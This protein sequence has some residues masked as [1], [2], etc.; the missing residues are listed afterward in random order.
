MS[1]AP[2][3]WIL[4]RKRGVYKLQLVSEAKR[5]CPQL[6]IILGED[7]SRFRDVSKTLAQFLRSFTWSEKCER[8]GFDEAWLDCTDMIDYSFSHLNQNDLQN[9]YFHLNKNDPLVGFVFDAS[10]LPG[11][12]HGSSSNTVDSGALQNEI[13]CLSLRLRLGAHLAQYLRHRLE[14]KGFTATV[15]ISVNKVLS[16]MIGS[17]H[18]P[19]AQTTLMPNYNASSLGEMTSVNSF[20]DAHDIGRIP[21]I[22]F[23]LTQKLKSFALARQSTETITTYSGDPQLQGVTVGDLRKHTNA[24]PQLF[25]KLLGGPGWPKDI[26]FR[27]YQLL[28]GVD[29]SEVGAFKK[30]PTQISIEDSY[31]RLDSMSE[32]RNELMKLS[33]SLLKRVRIDLMEGVAADDLESPN[34]Q[35]TQALLSTDS[36]PGEK[37]GNIEW[38][39]VPRTLRLS[40]RS[41]PP[42]KPDGSRVRT[43]NRISRSTP[44]PSFILLQGPIEDIVARLVNESLIPM[45]EKLHPKGSKWD[46][47]LLNV[48]VSNINVVGGD[49]ETAEG[50]N[51][52]R[53]LQGQN[54]SRKNARGYRVSDETGDSTVVEN[55]NVLKATVAEGSEDCILGTQETQSSFGDLLEGGESRAEFED[56]RACDYCEASMPSFAMEAH[57]RFHLQPD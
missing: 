11:Y 38:L 32:L 21:G 20:L 26:G 52:F 18:K 27:V 23:K 8:L 46:L 10:I 33:T 54:S 35:D 29:G 19:N 39:A 28:N 48:A 34:I 57:L 17:S 22:G 41:R 15:G 45:F 56:V 47:S 2:V 30:V 7:L 36:K 50:R 6:V 43:F 55:A 3:S 16:K 37:L 24:S 12:F 13:D 44:S 53:M 49:D 51:I 31:I 9:S 1:F 40:T 25:Q 4:A 14:E 5:T 42:R